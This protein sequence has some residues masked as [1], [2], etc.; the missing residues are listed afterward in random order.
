MRTVGHHENLVCPSS[1]RKSSYNSL[2]IDIN[3]G[4]GIGDTTMNETIKRISDFIKLTFYLEEITN[5]KNKYSVY[6]VN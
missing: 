5:K 1:Q 4:P 6:C 2:S 3:M